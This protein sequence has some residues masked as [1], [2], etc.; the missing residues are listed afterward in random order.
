[1]DI[2]FEA[3]NL[4]WYNWINTDKKLIEFIILRSQKPILMT[5]GKFSIMSLET[6]SAVRYKQ[7]IY[8]LMFAVFCLIIH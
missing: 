5:A 6:F 2:G 1:M 8:I 7:K 3:I 4:R